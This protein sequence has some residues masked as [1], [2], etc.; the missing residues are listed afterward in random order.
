[1]LGSPAPLR[2][3][4]SSPVS[5]GVL[6]M[7]KR[8]CSHWRHSEES[9]NPP[10]PLLLKKVSQY[11]SNLYCSTPP[12]SITVLLVPLQSEEREILSVLLPFVSQYVYRNMPPIC[13]TVLFGKILVVVV[14]GMFPNCCDLHDHPSR[15]ERID[16][17]F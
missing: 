11:A 10:P 3:L 2:P 17:S 13:I 8:A 4:S 5:L 15:T 7:P 6:I 9:Q 12:I 1:M 16:F 14:A